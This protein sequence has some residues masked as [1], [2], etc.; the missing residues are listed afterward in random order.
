MGVLGAV[1]EDRINQ[2]VDATITY[3]NDRGQATHTE[4]QGTDPTPGLL[5]FFPAMALI[6]GTAAVVPVV[7][8][9]LLIAE[10]ACRVGVPPGL[11]RG[12]GIAFPALLVLNQLACGRWAGVELFPLLGLLVYALIVRLPAGRVT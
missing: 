7:A 1:G 8:V 12:I 5:L 6:V 11:L 9:A 2:G 3:V 10:L 4:V